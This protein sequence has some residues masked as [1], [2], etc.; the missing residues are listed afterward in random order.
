MSRPKG[1][2]NYGAVKPWDEYGLTEAAYRYRLRNG[3]PLDA[4][5]KRG[6]KKSALTLE[7]ERLVEEFGEP[8]RKTYGRFSGKVYENDQSKLDAIR[9][10]YKN[11]VTDEIVFEFVNKFFPKEC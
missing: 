4:V 9:E 8:G 5:V 1:S 2:K 11:G 10:K 7:H 3:I 6:R